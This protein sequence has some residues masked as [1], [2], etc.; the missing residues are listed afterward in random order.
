MTH[1]RLS[2]FGDTGSRARAAFTLVE[3]LVV[4]AI[5]GVLVGLLL[6]AVQ[7]AREAARRSSCTNNMKQVA[8][9]TQNFNDAKRALPATSG[10]SCCWVSGQNN[11]NAGRRSAYVDLLPFM[12]EVTMFESIQAGLGG[13]P[14]GGPYGYSSWSVWDTAPASLRCPSD[15]ASVALN[16]A[17][18]NTVLCLGD[19][20]GRHGAGLGLDTS[21]SGRFHLARGLWAMAAY[22]SGTQVTGGVRYKECTD[23]LSK[24]LLLSER[25]RSP[26]AL[27]VRQNGLVSNGS[28]RTKDGIAIVDPNNCR[29]IGPEFMATGQAYKITSGVRWTDGAAENIGFTAHLPPNSAS[30][31]LDTSTNPQSARWMTLSA[32]SEHPGGANAAFGDG[33]VKFVNDYVSVTTVNS[34]PVNTTATPS[35]YSLWGALGSKAGGETG[36]ID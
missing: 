30:C 5:I 8:L 17:G 18:F 28:V 21:A 14:R 22:V 35:T 26:L 7:T 24:T 15:K 10:G 34:G 23:G 20:T 4:I 11:N 13:R 16:P 31:T 6:P 36:S 27:D 1:V 19:A 2:V 3:L 25:V 32:N 9:A 33:A 29:T 12:E